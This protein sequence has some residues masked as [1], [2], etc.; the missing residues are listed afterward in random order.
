MHPSRYTFLIIPDHD[1][2]NKRF[3]ISRRRT[4]FILVTIISILSGMVFALIYFTPKALDHKRMEKR[5]SEVIG[6]RTK[7]LELYRDLE[8]LKQMELVVQKALGTDL[9]VSE[10]GEGNLVEL[11]NDEP[12]HLAYLENIPSILPVEGY[13]TQEMIEEK[14]AD[15]RQHFGVDIAVQSGEPV[16][17]SAQGQVVFA[18][19][20]PEL[21]NLAV[22]YHGNEYFTY[23]G[24]N[25]LLLVDQ[26]QE[27]S[28]GDIIATSGNSG[29][30]SGPHLHF[31]IWKDG[32][33]VDPLS[34]FP[35]LKKSNMS[36]E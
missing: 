17:A 32:E 20:T 6:E 9:A 33:A 26:Y 35:E 4:L 2:E 8:R 30:S 27:V 21:G 18:G 22:I 10:S 16:M 24:H 25:E 31:E 29:M 19:W 14:E 12:I 13:L 34:Y 3:S 28:R 11:M 15:I 5:Y 7:V 23:Y 1:G 36:V